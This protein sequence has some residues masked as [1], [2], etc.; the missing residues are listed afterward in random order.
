MF[1][2]ITICYVSTDTRKVYGTVVERE[3]HLYREDGLPFS[4]PDFISNPEKYRSN[5][6]KE[7]PNEYFVSPFLILCLFTFVLFLCY[8]HYITHSYSLPSS[9]LIPILYYPHFYSPLPLHSYF[10]PSSFLFSTIL[11]PIFYHP[12]SYSLLSSFLFSTILIPILYYPHFYSPL[13]LHSYSL[14]SSFLFSVTSS[15]LFSTILIPIRHYPHSYSLPSSFLFSISS[16]LFSIILNPI[17]DS[18]LYLMSHQWYI[19]GS[20]CTQ[21]DYNG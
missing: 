8:I 20:W 2:C 5:F 16:F 6:A 18:S 15:F 11:I 9:F 21:I 17:P 10:L 12:H 3:D 4:V 14:P 7:V 19:L 13:P 1:H